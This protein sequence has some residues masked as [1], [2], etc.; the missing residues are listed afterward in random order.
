VRF[1]TSVRILGILIMIFSVTMLFPALVALLYDD[2]VAIPFFVTFCITLGTGFLCWF[3]LRDHKKELKIRDGFIIVVLFWSV[4]SLF[5]SL[6]FILAHHPDLTFTDAVFESVS[7][8]TTTGASILDSIDFLPRSILYY[9]QQLQFLGGMGII[10]LAVAVLPM[11]G[12]GG[13]QL[14]RAEL[15]GPAK[16][17]KLTPRIAESAKFLWYLYVGLMMACTLAYWACGMPFFYA[18]GESFSTVSTGGFSMHDAS[19]AYYDNYIINLV[20]VVFMVLGGTNFSLHF[21]A[22]QRRNVGI[23]WQDHEFRAYI[24]LLFANVVIVAIALIYY[25][26]YTEPEKAFSEALFNVVSLGTNTGLTSAP[27]QSWPTFVPFLMMI[28]ALVG[29]CAA[30]TAGGIKVIRIL[31][32]YHQ[33]KNEIMRLIHPKAIMSV[34]LGGHALPEHIAQAIWGFFATFVMFSFFLIII[35][36]ATGMDLETAFGALVACFTNA[37]VGIGDVADNFTGAHIAGKWVLIFTMIA[38][39]LEIFTLLVLFTPAFWRK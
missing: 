21:L 6:P 20:G 27:F 28:A 13:L 29:G 34:K 9:R 14:Y 26:T 10:V 11:L 38:G 16:D 32:V 12:I 2:G 24:K 23:Y 30:S 36:M 39:R 1:F 8:L 31:I 25:G 15:P 18:L 3:L 22:L 17:K 4:L 35:L 5:G 7:G 37:G 33:S 19:F